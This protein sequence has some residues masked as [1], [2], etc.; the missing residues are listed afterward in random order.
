MDPHPLATLFKISNYDEPIASEFCALDYLYE[1]L[2]EIRESE[3]YDELLKEGIYKVIHDTSLNGKL[4]CNDV[5]INSINVNCVSDMQ[6]PKLGDAC[7][8]VSTTYCNDHDWG[9][10]DS[11]DLENFI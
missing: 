7:F 5:I 9:D 11:Y 6:N 10:N 1:V 2:L 4:D 8:A 3:N